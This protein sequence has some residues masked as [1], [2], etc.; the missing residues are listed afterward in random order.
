MVALPDA[1]YCGVSTGTG[2]PDTSV[3]RLGETAPLICNFSLSVAA[4]E[5]VYADLRY[6]VAGALSD[7]ETN[8]RLRHVAEDTGAI[9]CIKCRC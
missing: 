6:T 9:F 8:S 5:N 7:S 3:L 1:W 4:C 2:W